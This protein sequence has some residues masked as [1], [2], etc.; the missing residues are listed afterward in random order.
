M[1]RADPVATWASRVGLLMLAGLAML[2]AMA[3]L[4][5]A[6]GS[7][8]VPDLVFVLIAACLVRRPEA[9]PLLILVTL[10]LV[11][12]LL[13]GAPL[14]IGTLALLGIADVLGRQR[15]SLVRG[16]FFAEWLLVSLL[17]AGLLAVQCLVLW[18]TFAG[19]PRLSTILAHLLLTC[20]VYPAAALTLRALDRRAEA[21]QGEFR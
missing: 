10:S 18:I 7:L 1:E 4:G 20:A 19:L 2:L 15:D 14:G 21:G 6:A 16:P 17:F 3:P 12:D 11:S 5:L 8:P 9:V 13:R